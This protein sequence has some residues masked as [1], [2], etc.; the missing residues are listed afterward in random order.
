M[1]ALLRALVCWPAATLAALTVLVGFAAMVGEPEARVPPSSAEAKFLNENAFVFDRA[2]AYF[3][4][5][6]A[7]LP[8]KRV[9]R[10]TREQLD[11]SV[12]A[13]LPGFKVGSVKQA[14]PRDP[15][16]TNYEYAEM[17]GLNQANLPPLTQWIKAIAT[18]AQ[19]APE[20]VIPC[21]AKGTD[22]RCLEAQARSF[23]IRAFRGFAAN[24]AVDPIAKFYL[25]AV[26]LV[27]FAE[28]TAG[29]VEVVLNS[30]YFLF[31]KELDTDASGLLAPAQRLE[32]LAYMLADAP[33]EKVGLSSVKAE[34]H[35]AGEGALAKS[36]DQIL[37]SADAR[38]KLVRF[39]LAWL[40]VKE[41]QDFRISR[42]EVP[43]FTDEVARAMTEETERFLRAKL[44]ASNPRPRLT[45]ITQ[46][47][48]AFVSRPLAQIYS[49]KAVDADGRKPIELEPTQR[50]GIFS[51]P[52]V[53]ASHSGPV[54]T[55][56]VKRG[57]FFARKVMC[58][59]LGVP[60]PGL[61]KTASYETAQ[62]TERQRIEALTAKK[63][64]IGCHKII[65]PFGFFQESYDPIGRWRTTDNGYPVDTTVA[66]DFLDEEPRTTEGPVPALKLLTSSMRFKQCFLRQLFRYYV[67]REEKA[68]D[69][70]LLRRM[71]MQFAARDEQD[72][73]QTLRTLA[74]D[75][76]LMRRK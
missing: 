61:A 8:Q 49:A 18:E 74:L 73:V 22:A 42:E 35:V 60:D 4:A 11:R 44:G 27:G 45:D 28:A 26:P 13:L 19:K 43:E 48:H 36:V 30:P 50:L 3:P 9:F 57:V 25:G 5:D 63:A 54:G 47:T 31:R 7:T 29:L 41:P 62:T 6:E 72:L 23:V 53:I 32:T 24:E 68:G 33:P 38:E 40:E 37:A 12:L 52:A 64:C 21:D 71:L 59:E 67:G 75:D 39:F 10:L 15:L 46:A 70:P 34:A 51:Q 20:K 17:L 2:R 1:R 65:D 14:M 66:I 69:E 58:M 76:R 55:R 56:P 16:L